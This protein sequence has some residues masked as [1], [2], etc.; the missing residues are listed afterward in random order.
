MSEKLVIRQSLMS[1]YREYLNGEFCGEHI[2]RAYLDPDHEEQETATQKMRMGR[3]FEFLAGLTEEEEPQIL[4]PTG[5]LASSNDHIEQQAREVKAHLFDLEKNRGWKVIGKQVELKY[6]GADDFIYTG[7]ADIVLEDEKGAIVIADT[8]LSGV[9][10][11][12]YN[13]YGFEKDTIKNSKKMQF[14]PASYVWLYYKMFG[15]IPEFEYW[16]YDSKAL[17]NTRPRLI[18]SKEY[19]ESFGEQLEKDCLNLVT[20]LEITK[21]LDPIPGSD[22]CGWCPF[23][24]G[25]EFGNRECE[26]FALESQHP[27]IKF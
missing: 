13:G 20:E 16:A 10:T 6:E 8:K 23:K 3:R 17:T 2:M 7:T 24:K 14:Q 22:T 1:K 18:F 15:V 4:T 5:R 21:R 11:R 9:V 12:S 26:H 27:I 25:N 19:I